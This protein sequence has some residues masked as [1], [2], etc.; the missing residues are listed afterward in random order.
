MYDFFKNRVLDF[1]VFW[2]SKECEYKSIDF[3]FLEK[4]NTMTTVVPLV[5]FVIAIY[6][7]IYN[8]DKFLESFVVLRHM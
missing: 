2:S 4:G 6:I 1:N 5:Y 3:H 7:G 8:S